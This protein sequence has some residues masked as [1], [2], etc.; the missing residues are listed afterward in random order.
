M[1]KTKETKYNPNTGKYETRE[2]GQDEKLLDKDKLQDAS[3]QDFSVKPV[4]QKDEE[5]EEKM[6]PMQRAAFRAKKAREKQAT[7]ADQAAALRDSEKKKKE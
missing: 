3:G 6:S 1:P 5:D 4:S 7:A 2:V